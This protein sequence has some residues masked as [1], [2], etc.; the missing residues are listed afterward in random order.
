MKRPET[1]AHFHASSFKHLSDIQQ[2]QVGC[3]VGASVA[4]AAIRAVDGCTDS[5][6][7]NKLID[8][9]GEGE[10]AFLPR[11]DAMSLPGVDRVKLESPLYRH[12]FTHEVFT[13]VLS[14]LSVTQRIT[15]DRALGV[16][17]ALPEEA[18][19][20]IAEPSLFDLCVSIPLHTVYPWTSDDELRPRI[21]SVLADLRSQANFPFDDDAALASQD[22]ALSGGGVILRY[23]QSNPQPLRNAAIMAIDGTDAMFGEWSLTK[24]NKEAP[25]PTKQV[26][27]LLPTATTAI[28]IIERSNSFAAGIRGCIRSM[29][30]S[31][32]LAMFVG[33]CLGAKYGI[34]QI[35]E[36][37]ITGTDGATE[38]CDAAIRLSQWSWNPSESTWNDGN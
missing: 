6:A 28:Q 17:H 1:P 9:V 19:K 15:L 18:K 12:S 21:C 8:E 16:I 23:L 2:K 3:I 26:T 13:A 7:L 14:E 25:Q 29:R 27:R 5:N 4:D 37:W 30:P 32:H 20:E 22:V 36:E 11:Q 31:C 33:A 34:R 10:A 24:F 38:V 35:P